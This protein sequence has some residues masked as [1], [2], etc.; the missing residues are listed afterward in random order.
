ME[1]TFV[2]IKPNGVSQGLIGEV[3]NRYEKAR[4]SI[5]AMVI[6]QLQQ[7]K[8]EA[9]YAEH[10]RQDFFAP[11]IKFMT[12]APVVLLVLSGDNAV[13]TARSV[14][15]STSPADAAPGTIRYDF[16][17]D[18]RR[19]IVHASDSVNSAK[20]EIAFWFDKKELVYYKPFSFVKA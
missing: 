7:D 6:K 1:S 19:N 4:L 12:T 18:T 17:P 2:I 5:S 15:G 11:L 8:V 14:N 9:F 16:A 13:Q 3:I 10:K 20:R